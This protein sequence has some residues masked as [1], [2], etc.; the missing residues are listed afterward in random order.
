MFARAKRFRPAF[1]AAALVGLTLLS[2]APHR[3]A[4][5]NDELECP[6]I[7]L[8]N[9][10]VLAEPCSDPANACTLTDDGCMGAVLAFIEDQL[11]LTQFT[12]V[13]TQEYI[14]GCVA[15]FALSTEV[16]STIPQETL[17][18]MITCDY[19]DIAARIEANYEDLFGVTGDSAAA[20]EAK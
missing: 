11:D 4:A 16:T 15:P 7:D 20:P 8:S 5:Q 12:S 1:V 13:P 2:T 6:E 17:G 3:A 10:G 19:D 18:A 14:T 9:I